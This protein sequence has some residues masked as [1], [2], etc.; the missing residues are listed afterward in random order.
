MGQKGQPEGHEHATA[1]LDGLG[2]SVAC[3][4]NGGLALWSSCQAGRQAS[5]QASN[6]SQ[7]SKLAIDHPFNQIK[8]SSATNFS[9]KPTKHH[10]CDTG[11]KKGKTKEEKTKRASLC[12]KACLHFMVKRG[13]ISWS[14]HLVPSSEKLYLADMSLA[15]RI[16]AVSIQKPAWLRTSL[17]SLQVKDVSELKYDP[18]ALAPS[19]QAILLVQKDVVQI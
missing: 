12:R 4:R 14:L 1:R 7:A 11:K 18:R 3:R 5:T 8:Q 17:V 2:D 6:F 9:E 16:V 10:I 13:P 15:P 19:K